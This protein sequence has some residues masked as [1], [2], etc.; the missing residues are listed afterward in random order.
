MLRFILSE[1]LW[2]LTSLIL[3]IFTVF[4][5][6]GDFFPLNGM[7]ISI[8]DTTIVVQAVMLSITIFLLINFIIYFIRIIRQSYKKVISNWI[9]IITGI[10]LVLDITILGQLTLTV[11]VGQWNLN[12]AI[13]WGTDSDLAQ[14]T[15]FDTANIVL[16]VLQ[17]ILLGLL[18]FVAFKWGR[19][20]SKS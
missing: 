14:T 13:G 4:A 1:L 20:R 11:G 17:I 9:F 2:L 6:T 10:L 15:D 16:M 18:M 7:D 8:H 12:S 5:F 3:A 19:N